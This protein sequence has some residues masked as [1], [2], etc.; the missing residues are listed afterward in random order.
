MSQT[1]PQ[2]SGKP[3]I[4]ASL[5]GQP[6]LL[7][8]LAPL[9]WG[10]NIVAGKAA[11]GEI[12][13]FLLI[14]FRWTG[15]VFLLL[16]VALP[17]LKR[18]WPKIRP[19]LP[20]LALYGILGFASF[21]MLMYG[22]AHFTAGVNASIEQAAIPVF[23]LIGN[24]VVFRVHARLLQVLGLILTIV[25]VVWVA[26]HGDPQRIV[27]LTV[28]IGDGMV[29]AACLLYA[30]YSLTLRFRPDIHWLSFMLVTAVFALA[31]SIVFQF[32]FGNGM[33]ALT[34]DL[35]EVTLI[36]WIC[37]LYVMVGPSIVAQMAY[38]RGV[39][40]VGPNRASIFINLLPVFGTILSVIVLHEALEL[41]HLIASA[42]VIAGI[43]LAEYAVRAT[44]AS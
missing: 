29:L 4:A 16:L 20:I 19:A 37:V 27:S 44:P 42:L 1:P 2:A 9:L 3:A 23:V 7:L 36:G 35:P 18:D 34:L 38:A 15:A 26:T 24:F 43:V 32:I 8:V 31:T 14:L 30:G 21:N 41:Y 28:N 33:Q 25:G 10:G 40:I 11:V 5:L 17:H 39:S 6:Y 13:P 22:A 12:S